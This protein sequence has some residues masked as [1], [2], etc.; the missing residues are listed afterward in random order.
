MQRIEHHHHHPA[1][2]SLS[3]RT[4]LTLSTISLLSCHV[5]GISVLDMAEARH[6]WRR[7]E[8]F[9]PSLIVELA[10]GSIKRCIAGGYSD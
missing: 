10:M 3:P 2:A 5:E 1:A 8:A 7:A 9:R 4:G 6:I